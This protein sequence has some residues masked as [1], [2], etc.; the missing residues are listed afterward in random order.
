M[1]QPNIKSQVGATI[2]CF[3]LHELPLTALTLSLNLLQGSSIFLISIALQPY[4]VWIGGELWPPTWWR[5]IERPGLA[6]LAI[7][8]GLL[9]AK[10]VIFLGRERLSEKAHEGLESWEAAGQ[11]LDDWREVSEESFLAGSLPVGRLC[12]YPPSGPIAC[13]AFSTLATYRCGGEPS[14]RSSNLKKLLIWP[15]RSMSCHRWRQL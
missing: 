11:C 10:K 12:Q 4:T 1:I 7:F 9:G 5:H 8:L 15:M 6:S 2:F 14:C 13:S 3:P